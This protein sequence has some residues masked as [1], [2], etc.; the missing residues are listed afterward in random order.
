[1]NRSPVEFTHTYDA[2]TKESYGNTERLSPN[3]ARQL[4]SDLIKAMQERSW[5]EYNKEGSDI[6]RTQDGPSEAK[7][8]YDDRWTLIY[9][10][11]T[12]MRLMRGEHEKEFDWE[13]G[14]EIDHG[15]S[16]DDSWQDHY[17]QYGYGAY[18]RG[19]KIGKRLSFYEDRNFTFS[20]DDESESQTEGFTITS[21]D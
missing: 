18:G 7:Q 12:G 10:I 5:A 6:T 15:I 1:M 3:D 17:D 16:G 11:S 8:V 4:I 13:R 21:Y 9:G 19:L 14:E 20:T 2:D